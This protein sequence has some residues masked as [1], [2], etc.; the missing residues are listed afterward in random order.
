VRIFFV[1][2][3][4]YLREIK[5]KENRF[6]LDHGFQSISM[7]MALNPWLAGSVA[8]MAVA[9]QKHHGR[10]VWWRKAALS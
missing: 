6:I 9:R 3:T 10:R 4:K 5:L 1:A 2:V 8:F 7:S